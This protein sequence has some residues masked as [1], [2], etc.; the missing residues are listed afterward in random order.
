MKKIFVGVGIAGCLW[1]VF[2]M[3]MTVGRKSV[4]EEC[5][6]FHAFTYSN[7]AWMCM[8]LRKEPAAEYPSMSNDGESKT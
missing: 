8:K 2:F 1:L 4:R 6:T 5:Y 7:E 3:G